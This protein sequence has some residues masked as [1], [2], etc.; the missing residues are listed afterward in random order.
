MAPSKIS[1]TLVKR[2]AEL[3]ERGQNGPAI[4]RELGL[5]K[6][7]V[8]VILAHFDLQQVQP[9][10]EP[11]PSEPTTDL[12]LELAPAREDAL[13]LVEQVQELESEELAGIFVGDDIEY[14]TPA[15]WD[16]ANSRQVQNPHIMI[17]GESGS[18]KTYAQQCLIAEL[19]HA[20]IPSIVFDFGQSFERDA[21]DKQFL[22]TCNPQEFLIGEEGLALNPLQIF[23]KDKGPYAVATRLADVFD[24]GFRLGDIQ[25]KALIDAIVRSYEKVGI[26]QSDKQSWRSKPPSI[27]TLRDTIDELASD[28]HYPNYKNAAG[29]SARLTTFFML[30]SFQADEEEWSWDQIIQDSLR[31]VHILQ[32]RGL[33]GKTQRVLVE[34]LLWH[35]FYHLKTH[36]QNSLRVFCVLDEAHHLSFR[37]SGPVNALLREARK[38]GLGLI[39]ASQQPE[40]FSPVAYSNSASKLVFQ[41]SD[42]MLKVSR[43][44]AGKASNYDRPEEIGRIISDLDQ[45]EAFFITK[46]RGYVVRVADFPKR[47]TMW[48]EK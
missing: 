13:S 33:E 30:A 25:K 9:F 10:N 12:W 8:S 19:A 28:R 4:A 18:G 41:T 20:G 29:L 14:E 6:M 40:D 26:T 23:E 24:A 32:F 35:L 37:E 17:M 45:G 3:S 27:G 31:R 1:E 7:Q 47:A 22:R 48:R 34:V 5:S 15:L 38:F 46:N 39:F 16:P 42:P 36:G 43:Y 21:L 2:I 11:P 44:L